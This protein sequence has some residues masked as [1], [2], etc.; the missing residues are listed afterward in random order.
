MWEDRNY[1][2]I[3]LCKN[4][5]YHLTR[6]T[7]FCSSTASRLAL[8]M[9]TCLFHRSMVPSALSAIYVGQCTVMS[10]PR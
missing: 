9:L 4:H 7:I 8:P 3:V 5:L 6:C 2:W 1:C 10:R